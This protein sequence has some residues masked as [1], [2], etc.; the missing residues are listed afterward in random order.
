MRSKLPGFRRPVHPR[1]RGEHC[2]IAPKGRLPAGSSPLARGTQFAHQEPE[3]FGQVHPR[4]RGEHPMAESC[5][6][7]VPGSSTLARGTRDVG[8]RHGQPSR[9]I[10][11]RA[12]NTAWVA[13]LSGVRPVHPR[14][15]GE[16]PED[17]HVAEAPA[18][19][20]PRARG[21]PLTRRHRCGDRRFIPARAGNTSTGATWKVSTKVH[22]RSRGE[23]YCAARLPSAASGSSPLARG[24]PPQTLR[25]DPEQRFIPARAGNTPPAASGGR[26][27]A[28]HPRSR[29]EHADAVQAASDISGSSPL[30]RGTR[31]SW[32]AGSLRSRFIP[33]RAGN[34]A[35]QPGTSRN[36][37][38]HPRSRGEHGVRPVSR[39]A[40]PR[41]IPARAGNTAGPA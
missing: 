29:G 4:S 9:F 14:S 18:G 24:T 10:P 6:F 28:V 19:S 21:T 38:V 13:E 22:P 31:N 1:S 5:L 39:L 8:D 41:F 40:G 37:G 11:A 20:S 30:A 2:G 7:I 16:H 35:T 23:H 36:R 32:C 15:R 12:G 3:L 25:L 33:A 26:A 17:A 34:T 27:A